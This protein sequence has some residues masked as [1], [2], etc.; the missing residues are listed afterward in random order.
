MAR[1]TPRPPP[2]LPET[3]QPMVRH[4]PCCG[5]PLWAADHN[6]RTITTLEALMRLTLQMRRGL[7]PACPHVRTPYRPEAAGR[8]ALPKPELGL[9]VLTCI[10]P[11]RSAHHHRVPTLQQAVIE[12]GLAVAPRTVTP[13][14]ER[15]DALVALSRQDPARLRRLTQP[16]GRVILALDGLQPDVGQAV[17]WVRR[18]GLSG[19]GLLARR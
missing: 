16:Q 6:S 1:T 15:S 10:G 14:L 18:A 13:L 7:H 4:C 19:E 9:D 8:L 2:T 3:V 12:R 17:L 5:D 11:P